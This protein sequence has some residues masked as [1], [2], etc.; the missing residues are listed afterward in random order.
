M[1]LIAIG[2]LTICYGF[3]THPDR[4]WANLL[5][6]NFFFMAIALAGTFFLAVQ[7]VAQAGW[8]TVIKRVPEATSQFLPFAA[9]FMII[10]FFLGGH[11][12]YHWTHKEL[13]DPASEHY[14]KIIAGKSGFLNMPFYITRMFLYFII[15]VG[16]TYLLRKESLQEDIDGDMKHYKR[17]LTWGALFVIF[18]AASS[19]SSAWDFLM[20]IDTHWFSTMF[21]WYTFAGLFVSGISVITIFTLYLKSRGYMQEVSNNH[22]HD[23][24]KFMF[25]F[26]VFWTYLWFCQ[27][28]LIWYANLPEEVIYFKMRWENGYKI[29]FIGNFFINFI[30]PFLVLMSRDAKRNRKFLLVACLII[31]CGHWMDV[32]LMV[33]PGTVGKDWGIG[34][35]E[36]GTFL[37]F[38]GLFMLVVFNSLAKANVVPKHH[39]LLSE[40]LQHHI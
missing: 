40:S 37:G 20:S 2:V 16:F 12:L 27:F 8:S 4:Q 13:Y 32:F 26:S 31:F 30:M 39:P 36:I 14:D 6:D 19:S 24:G 5:V 33:M 28:M 35:Q 3:M 34:I 17:C 1:T 23:L 21:G 29:L 10:I 7:Y 9:I 18:F 15:W 38:A 22:L 11:T 25:A